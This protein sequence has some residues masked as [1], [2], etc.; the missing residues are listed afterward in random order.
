MRAL[1][2]IDGGAL[3]KVLYTSVLAGVSVAVVFAL[4]IFGATRAG[5]MRRAG[6]PDRATGY[7]A[8]GMVALV[9]SIAIA[10]IGLV[11]VTR[12]S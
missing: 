6:R 7:A 8:L 9:A 4:A 3:V 11:L 12:K 5:D 1:G 2:S 10:V